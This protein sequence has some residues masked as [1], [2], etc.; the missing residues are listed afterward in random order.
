MTRDRLFVGALG[1][2]LL[3]NLFSGIRQGF[4]GFF[5]WFIWPWY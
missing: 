5:G 1:G 4:P 3:V 2:L